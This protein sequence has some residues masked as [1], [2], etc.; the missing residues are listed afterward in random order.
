MTLVAE[1]HAVMAGYVRKGSKDYRRLQLARLLKFARFAQ[2][3]GAWHPGQV[4]EKTFF[5][6]AEAEGLSEKTVLSY[7]QAWKI[8]L[9]RWQSIKKANNS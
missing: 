4:G 9:G 1:V 7:R 3:C 2:A 5:K 8:F 6:F